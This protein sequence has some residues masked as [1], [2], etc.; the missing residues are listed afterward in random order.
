[1]K[2]SLR[3]LAIFV[4]A[5]CL[6]TPTFAQT[7][8]SL[9]DPQPSNFKVS[10]E[11]LSDPSGTNIDSYMSGLISEVKKHWVSL[12]A[13]STDRQLTKQEESVIRFTIAPDGHISAMQL[14]STTHDTVLDKTAWNATKGTSYSPLPM[15]MKDANLQ[16]RIHFI[17]N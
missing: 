2:K 17:V 4:L 8:S 9:S 16:I 1:M 13:E 6:M 11:L 14:E 3:F 7:T 15:G 10:V 5:P 12:V